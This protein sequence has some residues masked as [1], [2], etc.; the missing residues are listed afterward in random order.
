MWQQLIDCWSVYVCQIPLTYTKI[1]ISAVHNYIS[2]QLFP[3]LDT[4][5]LLYTFCLCPIYLSFFCSMLIRFSKLIFCSFIQREFQHLWVKAEAVPVLHLK[6]QF[7]KYDITA[8]RGLSLSKF[9]Q[10][11]VFMTP[12]ERILNWKTSLKNSGRQSLVWSWS[13]FIGR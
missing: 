6:T 13:K 3:D 8:F 12:C 2:M 11:P 7:L 9:K 1:N 5:P 10:D 4:F